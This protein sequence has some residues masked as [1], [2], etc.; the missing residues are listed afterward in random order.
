MASMEM[1][2]LVGGFNG[3]NTTSNQTTVVAPVLLET[4]TSFT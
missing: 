2:D 4:M 1:F 3:V